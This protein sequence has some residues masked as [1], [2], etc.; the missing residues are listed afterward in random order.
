[1]YAGGGLVAA[2]YRAEVDE[3]I[4][5]FRLIVKAGRAPQFPTQAHVD[6]VIRVRKR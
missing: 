4:L 2:V 5:A 6:V 1:M 3:R